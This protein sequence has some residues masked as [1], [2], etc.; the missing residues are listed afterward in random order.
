MCL[1]LSVCVS[2]CRSVR[3]SLCLAVFITYNNSVF[4]NVHITYF[5]LFPRI[6]VDAGYRN[7]GIADSPYAHSKSHKA[8]D[9]YK[10]GESS[11]TDEWGISDPKVL[12]AMI[13]RNKRMK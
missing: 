13:K 7:T 6:Y 5:K 10:G 9:L 4:N 12:Q 3:E 8:G 11:H 2:R 1:L